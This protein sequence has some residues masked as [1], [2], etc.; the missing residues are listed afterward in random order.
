VEDFLLWIIVLQGFAVMY[1]E[2]D[3]W[4]M[5]RHRFQERAV[6]RE[7]KR[8]QAVKKIEVKGTVNDK[9]G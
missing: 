1:F 3:V 8:K 9:V 2:Y 4:R 5:N 7:A 6:W